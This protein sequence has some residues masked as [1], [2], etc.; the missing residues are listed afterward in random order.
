M[1]TST[2][3]NRFKNVV[4]IAHRL[5]SNL[6]TQVALFLMAVSYAIARPQPSAQIQ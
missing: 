3:L 4:S 5:L 2:V 1:V 6:V